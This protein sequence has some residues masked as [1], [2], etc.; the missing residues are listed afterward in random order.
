MVPDQRF[1]RPVI[2][3]GVGAVGPTGGGRPGR[4]GD[5]GRDAVTVLGVGDGARPE[6]G[7]AALPVEELLVVA[8]PKF[9][10]GPGLCSRAQQY[11]W[12]LPV[13]GRS[14]SN[15]ATQDVRRITSGHV[16]QALAGG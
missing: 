9:L 15:K 14:D 2:R 10:E 3:V 6:P 11:T 16:A 5:E 13:L 8:R 4:P 7:P 1:R 12:A